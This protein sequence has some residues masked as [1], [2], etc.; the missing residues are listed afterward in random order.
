MQ[1][2]ICSVFT[3]TGKKFS[4]HDASATEAGGKSSGVIPRTS[5]TAANR[6]TNLCTQNKWESSWL[7]MSRL[8]KVHRK[9][10]K[11]SLTWLQKSLKSMHLSIQSLFIP[12]PIFLLDYIFTV[13]LLNYLLSEPLS[14]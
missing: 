2:N 6:C 10:S 7:N 5:S 11:T 13:Y 4:F 14:H 3:K 9:K 1:L 8:Q 12:L